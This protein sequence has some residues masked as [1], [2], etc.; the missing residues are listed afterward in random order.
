MKNDLCAQCCAISAEFTNFPD[1]KVPNKKERDKI[2]KM[3]ERVARKLGIANRFNAKRVVRIMMMELCYP[4]W[5]PLWPESNEPTWGSWKFQWTGELS[6][7]SDRWEYMRLCRSIYAY[8]RWIA[9]NCDD[10][11]DYIEFWGN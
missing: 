4:N 1:G 8:M 7:F 11:L 6:Y 10:A 5:K 2:Q 3:Y 9:E